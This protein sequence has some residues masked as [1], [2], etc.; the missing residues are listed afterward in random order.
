MARYEF[1]MTT[2]GGELVTYSALRT[3]LWDAEDFLADVPKKSPTRVQRVNYA[4]AFFAARELGKLQ[5]LGITSEDPAEGIKQMVNT[6]EF[7]IAEAP[8][9]KGPKES[10]N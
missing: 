6:C 8:L 5:E 3:A 10:R 2:E 4:W 9:A 7:D 1:H